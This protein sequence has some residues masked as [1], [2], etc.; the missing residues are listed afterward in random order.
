MIN[1]AKLILK[2]LPWL[3]TVGLLGWMLIQEKMSFSGERITEIETNTILTKVEQLGN[4]E[5]VKYNF[6]EVTEIR[7]IANSID[8]KLFKYKPLPDSKGV[9]ISQGSAAGCIDLSKIKM[10]DIRSEGDTIYLSLP[11]PEICYFKIDLEKSRLYDLQIEYMRQEDRKNF[12]QELYKVAEEQIKTSALESGI[13]E[14]T[15]ENAHSVLRP[16]LE[17][18]SDKTIILSFELEQPPIIMN[19]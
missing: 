12:V 17:T 3:L 14:Q 2:I 19:D 9:L 8:F 5:L 15:K 16:I 10:E 6:Q 7:K 18:I 1:L 4:M 11:A 13:L